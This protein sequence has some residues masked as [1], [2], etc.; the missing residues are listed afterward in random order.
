MGLFPLLAPTCLP[1]VTLGGRRAGAAGAQRRGRGGLD[2]WALAAAGPRGLVSQEQPAPFPGA[3]PAD[4]LSPAPALCC[5][6]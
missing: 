1:R 5:Q 2:C 6:E 3:R 4:P